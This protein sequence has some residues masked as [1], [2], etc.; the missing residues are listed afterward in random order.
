MQSLARER[1]FAPRNG[2]STGPQQQGPD[3]TAAAAAAALGG[4]GDAVGGVVGGAVQA[5]AA[6]AADAAWRI[7]HWY[8]VRPPQVLTG[9][10][11]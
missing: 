5:V 2:N 10:R 7:P 11:W 8:S 1:A 9:E 6:A 4:V 3:G